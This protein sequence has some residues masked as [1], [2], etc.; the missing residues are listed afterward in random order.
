MQAIDLHIFLKYHFTTIAFGTFFKWKSVW[1]WFPFCADGLLKIYNQ[2]RLPSRKY[3]RFHYQPKRFPS[4]LVITL[5][6]TY[7]CLRR[8]HRTYSCACYPSTRVS[9]KEFRKTKNWHAAI[10][11]I[12]W[13]NCSKILRP[14]LND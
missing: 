5:S 8:V 6:R 1:L 14:N 2:H 4:I 9:E 11:A 13:D 12:F 7:F 3:I 10:V